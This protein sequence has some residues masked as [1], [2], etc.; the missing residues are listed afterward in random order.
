MLSPTNPWD[1]M[2][3]ALSHE[4]IQSIQHVDRRVFPNLQGYD[5]SPMRIVRTLLI[6]WITCNTW[7]S[8][9][10]EKHIEWL[11]ARQN[12]RLRINL[13]KRLLEKEV[14][15]DQWQAMR[16]IQISEQDREVL[17][18]KNYRADHFT[19]NAPWMRFAVQGTGIVFDFNPLSGQIIRIDRTLHSGYNFSAIR[20]V[21]NMKIFSIGGEG[22]WSYNKHITYFDDQTSKEWEL[23]RPK[24]K[25]PEHI[26]DGFQGYSANTDI[27]YSGGSNNKNFLE[28][29]KIDFERDFYQFDFKTKTWDL[30]GKI[31]DKIPLAKYR[32]IYWTGKH[33]VQLATDRLYII[34]PAK[35]EVYMYKDNATY[36]ESSGNHFVNGDT[37]K[38]YHFQHRGPLT[39]IP[40]L[41]LLNKSTYEGPFYLTDYSPYYYGFAALVSIM[42]IIMFIYK[43]KRKLEPSF[44]AMERKLLNALIVA[45][46]S[47]ISTNELNDILDCSQ[48]SQE[49]Q[50]RI[51][52]MIIKQVNEKLAFYYNIKNAIERTASTEDKRLITYRLKKGVKD[53][54]K[55]IL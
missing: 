27:F 54:I 11:P 33:F 52:F 9:A 45:G 4:L 51:R 49:N 19:F 31:S 43:T 44:D 5:F 13:S 34:D 48:K 30:L 17:S 29:E 15:V 1:N 25:G 55:A 35:N 36:F 38:Y 14:G 42:V 32:Q 26:S 20:F 28:D 53:K 46:E 39:S 3:F 7:F 47:S 50:R 16:P 24:N 41:A 8:S 40:V 18:T 10:Q 12:L 22:F 23:F 2:L 21:R 37:I 6:C